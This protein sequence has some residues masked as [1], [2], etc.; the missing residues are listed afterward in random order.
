MVLQP[1]MLDRRLRIDLVVDCLFIESISSH[2]V[3]RKWLNSYVQ[4]IL[5][6]AVRKGFV[7]V[8]HLVI[9]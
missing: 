5:W 8:R 7:E 1:D 2:L 6:L 4:Q 3:S 9:S